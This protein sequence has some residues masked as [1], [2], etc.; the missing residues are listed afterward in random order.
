[1]KE[2]IHPTIFLTLV[3]FTFWGF[4]TLHSA[5][6]QWPDDS[7]INLPIC[8]ESGDQQLPKIV[9]DGNNGAI[10]AWLD[11]RNSQNDI[12]IQRVDAYGTV[13]WNFEGIFIGTISGNQPHEIV[14][15]G[16]GG[17]IVVWTTGRNGLRAQRINDQ[18]I[19]KWTEIGILIC[20]TPHRSIKTFKDGFGGIIITWMDTRNGYHDLYAQRVDKNGQTKWKS[21]G[22]SIL[23][24]LV[25]PGNDYNPKIIY[26]E[27]TT[28]YAGGAIIVWM[29][30][31]GTQDRL[32]GQRVDS[33]GVPKWTENGVEIGRTYCTDINLKIATDRFGGAIITWIDHRS[34]NHDVYAQ[35][36]D[37]SGAVKWKTDGVAICKNKLTQIDQNLLSFEKGYTIITWSDGRSSTINN[38]NYYIYAQCINLNGEILWDEKGIELCSFSNQYQNQSNHYSE[39]VSD[40]RGGAIITWT[41]S[42]RDM[43]ISNIYAQRV[44]RKGEIQW[45]SSCVIVCNADNYQVSPKIVSDG[46]GGGI[47]TWKDYR[48]NNPDIYA[49]RVFFN[50]S[51]MSQKIDDF[52]RYDGELGSSWAAHSDLVISN[53]SNLHNRSTINSWEYLGVYNGVVNPKEVSI[54]W[55]SANDGCDS[56]GAEASGITFVDTFSPYSSGYLIY[57]RDGKLRLWS[58]SNSSTIAQLEFKFVDEPYPAPGRIMKVIF[59]NEVYSFK[60]FIN[61]VHIATISDSLKRHN[62]SNFYGGVMMYGNVKNDI[63]SFMAGHELITSVKNRK[64][65]STLK[66]PIS[67]ILGQNYPNPFNL[68]TTIPFDLVTKSM[69]KIV[70]IDIL[71][72]EVMTITNREFDAGHYKLNL[73]LMSLTSGVYFYK[74]EVGGFVEVKKMVLIK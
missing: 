59:D 14:D 6:V 3:I 8:T 39:L 23:T 42:S 5:S 29:D 56:N 36:I 55:A 13:K 33:L 10:I 68:E 35:R 48:N 61:N 11:N 26:P 53:N 2:N 25:T 4:L 54:E 38:A 60:V 63:E 43:E 50:A 41:A 62:L 74:L 65:N 17:V 32:F 70:L 31:R 67:L 12:Y 37:S 69:V 27:I 47:I 51:I 16:N 20:D 30:N 15:D 18:G 1:M 19:K 40:C 45:G 49:Q 21:N 24:G 72:Q 28:D 34:D 73:N 9:S 71:G 44:N 7:K 46:L 58:I 52:E 64:F 57:V 66:T 22:T